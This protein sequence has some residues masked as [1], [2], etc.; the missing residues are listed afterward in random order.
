MIPETSDK[1]NEAWQPVIYDLNDEEQRFALGEIIRREKALIFNDPLH[2]QLAELVEVLEPGSF[3][4]P[5]EISERIREHLGDTNPEYYGRWVF[6][7]WSGQMVHVLPQHEFRRLR[8]D[9]NRYKITEDEQRQLGEFCI[10]IVGMSAG[11]SIAI[12]MALEGVGGTFYLADFD[13]LGLTNLNRLRAG[14]HELGIN[15]ALLTA[16]RMFEIDPYLDIKIFRERLGGENLNSFLGG[17]CPV[18]L[19][20]EECDDL[21]IKV[22]LREH[23]REQ[24]TPVVMYTSDRGLLDVERFDLEPNRPVFHGLIGDVEAETLRGLNV[25]EKTPYGLRIVGEKTISTRMR[26][27]LPE[28][29]QSLSGWPQLASGTALGSGI[30]PDVARRILLNSFTKSGRFMVDV[31]GIVCD[32]RIP[33]ETIL[34][35]NASP[36]DEPIAPEALTSVKLQTDMRGSDDIKADEVIAMVE[37]GVLAPSGGN[38][39]P[40]TF[41]FHRGKLLAQHDVAR[42]KCLLDFENTASYLTFGA[43]LENI[44]LAAGGMGIEPDI[45]LFPGQRIGSTMFELTFERCGQPRTI[46]PLLPQVPRRI[47]NRNLGPRQSLNE[48]ALDALVQAASSRQTR[49]QLCTDPFEL[50]E[51]GAILGAGE[52]FRLLTRTTHQEMFEEVRWTAGEVERTRDGIDV[53]TLEL[54]AADLAAMKLVSSWPAMR[55]LGSIGG[56]KVLERPMKDTVDAAS[57]VG[58]M[59]VERA[60]PDGFFRGGRAMQRVWLTATAMDLAF[61]PI[62]PLIFLFARLSHGNGTGLTPIGIRTLTDLQARFQKVFDISQARDAV[63][64]FRVARAAPPRARSLRRPVSDVLTLPN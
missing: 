12:T 55:F 19:L 3:L 5:A 22:L 59:T 26:A 29:K 37:H 57:A 16:R 4:M 41:E 30:V 17:E 63:M 52:R 18:D 46:D 11:R 58:L 14:V 8:T 10:G 38:C 43:A 54:T 31:E 21:F 42:S 1:K 23:A 44:L 48:K 45:R 62:T 15:K 53:A 32:K 2:D 64:L 24:G 13:E 61:Q 25:R 7:P 28:I 51:L 27:S 47:T 56:G 50:D 6:Y 39:Q 34:E 33:V 40:W 35:P 60:G 9:R 20:V 49:L 36:L